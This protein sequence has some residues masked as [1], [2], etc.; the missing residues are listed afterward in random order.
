MILTES[1]VDEL[2]TLHAVNLHDEVVL[3]GYPGN[4]AELLP[5]ALT[6]M[7]LAY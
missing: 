1:T 5:L 2:E 3:L 6:F 4:Q 7:Q